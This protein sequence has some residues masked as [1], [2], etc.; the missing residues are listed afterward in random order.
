[1]GPKLITLPGNARFIIL[2]VIVLVYL[3]VRGSMFFTA[4]GKS[5]LT[6]GAQRDY[7]LA[8]GEIGRAHV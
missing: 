2:G 4:K 1:M 8:G 6:P 5:T 3:V 7:G